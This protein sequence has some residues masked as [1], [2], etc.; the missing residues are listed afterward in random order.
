MAGGTESKA[1]RLSVLSAETVRANENWPFGTI[2]LAR[3]VS[4]RRGGRD[5][6]AFRHDSIGPRVL[7]PGVGNFKLAFIGILGLA[8][9]RHF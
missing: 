7:L 3:A 2:N 6:M 4:I 8:H 1:R 9:A 5:I